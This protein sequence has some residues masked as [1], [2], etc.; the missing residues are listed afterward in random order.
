ML[1]ETAE[2][3]QADNE[4]LHRRVENDSTPFDVMERAA[5]LMTDKKSV[6]DFSIRNIAINQSLKQRVR[7][8]KSRALLREK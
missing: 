6:S 7:S 2:Y 5:K 4:E 8:K 1:D 3:F